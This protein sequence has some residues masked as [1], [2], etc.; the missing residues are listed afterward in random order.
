M[1]LAHTAA[2]TPSI[3][4]LVFP[5]GILDS[6]EVDEDGL[7]DNLAGGIGGDDSQSL[8]PLVSR[9][10]VH[11]LGGWRVALR[12]L[13]TVGNAVQDQR[14]WYSHFLNLPV[15]AF[16]LRHGGIGLINPGNVTRVGACPTPDGVPQTALPM[17]LLRWSP[18]RI[19]TAATLTAA[20]HS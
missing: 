18:S 4:P 6:C 14:N 12:I 16:R 10:E 9:V 15:V 1:I 2:Q 7:D 3:F 13:A 11:T 5:A 20:L 19:K 17:E 8:S